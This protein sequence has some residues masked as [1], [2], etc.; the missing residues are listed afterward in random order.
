MKGGRD[1]VPFRFGDG[2]Q[3][4]DHLDRLNLDFCEPVVHAML[5][6]MIKARGRVWV[7]PALWSSPFYLVFSVVTSVHNY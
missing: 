4:V 7:H 6:L 1:L 5:D 2:L 3:D